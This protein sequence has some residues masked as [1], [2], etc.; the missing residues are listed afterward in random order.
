MK[1]PIIMIMISDVILYVTQFLIT[2][3]IYDKVIGRGNEG[4][5]VLIISTT[6]VTV[7][8]MLLIA[9]RFYFWL[10]SIIPYS[11]LII[12]YCPSGAYG[13]GIV[14]LDLDGLE[15]YYDASARFLGIFINAIFVV[16]LQFVIWGIIHFSKIVMKRIQA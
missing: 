2:P 8:G 7:I 10:I 5:A 6:I 15:S 14:G 4:T 3:C 16:L 12:L 1:K 9:D 11:M 13:I